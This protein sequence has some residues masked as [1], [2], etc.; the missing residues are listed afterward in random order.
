M[1]KHLLLAA[2]AALCLTAPA[3][4]IP[5]FDTTNYAQNLLTAARTLTMIN[6]QVRQLQNEA[7]ALL[8]EARNLTSLP[9]S[10]IAELQ[11]SMRESQRLLDQARGL[12][13]D[14]ADADA[15]FRRAYPDAYA[16]T[17]GRDRLAA[18][19]RERWSNSLEALRTAT[20]VQAQVATSLQRD[21]ATLVDLVGRSQGAVGSLQ[22]IQATNQLIALQTQQSMQ[23][24]RL[25]LAEGRATAL[26]AARAVAAEE[27]GR[28]NR[29][30]FA[31]DGAAY[32]PASVTMFHD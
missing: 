1:K 10:A 5:V 32:T 18:D 14:V 19:A 17:V 6:N 11:A 31:G 27:R 15:A 16:T 30:R 7:Q 8:N 25:A 4:A 20:Q 12:A 22:A 2:A 3:S 24:Q 28:E 13:F 9:T 21:E 26:E 23:Q 29:R